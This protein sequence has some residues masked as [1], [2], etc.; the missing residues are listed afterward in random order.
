[1]SEIKL[2]RYVG[3]GR[4]EIV[5]EPEPSLPPGGLLVQTEACGLCSG[6]L[7][8]W[9]MDQKLPHVLGHEVSGRVVASEDARFPVGARVFPH[10]HAPCGQCE[11]CLTGRPVHCP[12][13]KRTRLSPGGMATR[14]AVSAE[15]LSDTWVVDDLAPE[16]AALT[17]PLACVA[18]A[19]RMAGETGSFAVI[20]LGF[21]GLLH[22]LYRDGGVGY[23]INPS[24][25]AFARENGFE[26]GDDADR[27]QY[28]TVFVCPGSQAA[29]DT[30]LARTEPGATIV[31]FAPLPPGEVLRVPQAVYF[32]DL[33]IHHAYSA[34]PEDSK[35]ALERLGQPDV[36]WRRVVSHRI[37]LEEL[38][39]A[40]LA[41]REGRIVKPMV[42]FS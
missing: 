17:E 1:M 5:A 26:V 39:E 35:L 30:A 12:Q 22:L 33:T 34:G 42:D 15:N 21:M 25:Q 24:R 27:R 2:A 29:F 18:K 40:Y 9:Y 8:A 14:F 10:H 32:R 28:R 36:D 37:T 7:M 6:E 38:P 31:M 41:M 13:W 4:V 16:A 23:D 3:A 20:G 11:M 19:F